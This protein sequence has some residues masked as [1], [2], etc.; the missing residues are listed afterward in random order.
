LRRTE[1]SAG[2]GIIWDD[3]RMAGMPAVATTGL[4]NNLTKGTG[5]ELSAL[6]LG[7]FEDLVIPI[8]GAVDVLVDPYKF[9]SAGVVRVTAFLSLDV[10]LRHAASFV[11][12]SDIVTT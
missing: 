10:A 8:W 1:K 7:N 6:V 11:L 2:S 5:T 3:D 12:C 4:P 9:T